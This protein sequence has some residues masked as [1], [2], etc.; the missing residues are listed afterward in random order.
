MAPVDA[1]HEPLLPRE[2][3]IGSSRVRRVLPNRTRRMVGA[4]CLLDHL[5][6][7]DRAGDGAARSVPPHP[8][9]GQQLVTWLFHGALRHVDSLGS[10]AVVRPGQ[11]ALMTAGHG[12]CHAELARD[13]GA[14]P[15]DRSRLHGVQLWAC[16][17]D[18]LRDSAEPDFT[19]IAGLPTYA[20][21]GVTLTV[22]V[23]ELAG[24]VSTAP[25]HSPLLAAEIRLRP[26]S[27]AL[28]PLEPAFEHG[29]LGVAGEVLVEGRPVPAD[30]MAYLGD[31]RDGLRIEAPEGSGDEVVL[32]LL[33]GE[34]FAE[35]IVMWWNFVGRSHDD[36]LEQRAAWNGP[37]V[38]W[39]PPRYG[40]VRGFGGDRLL[41]PPLPPVRLRAR[42]REA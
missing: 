39:T 37:G 41:A 32:L 12:I 38:S 23:G 35:R 11:L 3:S 10:D 25:V 29:V 21:G 2:V 26:G 5:L 1:V 6:G 14:S 31:G 42:G 16:L 24:E 20:E 4:W 33:G 7:D 9:A 40:E 18:D 34:P 19:H 27:F 28:L 30:E 15:D 22:L 13:G 36:V 8:H 17:P